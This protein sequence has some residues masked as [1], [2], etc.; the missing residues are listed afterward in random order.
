MLYKVEIKLTCGCLILD[1]A[2]IYSNVALYIFLD[3]FANVTVSYN[4]KILV[5][6]VLLLLSC[7]VCARLL[8]QDYVPGNKTSF[9]SFGK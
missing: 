8:C 6:Y 5:N 1:F 9:S 3:K 2:Y 4:Y 7:I